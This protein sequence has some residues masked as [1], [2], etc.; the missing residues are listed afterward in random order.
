MRTYVHPDLAI[1][2]SFQHFCRLLRRVPVLLHQ[3][4]P[5][6]SQFTSGL[7]RQNVAVVCWIDDLRF[8][9][10]HQ[11]PDRI[12]ALVHWIVRCRHRRHGTGLRHAVTDGQ[13]REIQGPVQFP[14]QF[15][16]D[17]AARGYP[18]PQILESN[19]GN[20]A[21][22]QQPEL[23]EKHGG[24][25]V[26]CCAFF[27]LYCFQ[28]SRGIERFGRED[29]RRATRGRRHVAQDAPKTVKER[30]GTAHHVLR[31]EQHAIPNLGA[32]VQNRTMRET[33]CFGHGCCSRGELN[34]D[35]IVKREILRR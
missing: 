4:V 18:S 5:A 10:R 27:V 2:V 28:R 35:H 32:I 7:Y 23:L 19:M 1:P 22:L 13:L 20:F 30:R 34:V 16:G 6:D 29:D 17:A 31:G 33:G 11:P 9:M 24:D 3:Q 14:H 12:D 26:Q 21:A 15:R 8:D 25:P